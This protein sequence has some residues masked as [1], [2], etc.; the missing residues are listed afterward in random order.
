MVTQLKL[1]R[2]KSGIKQWRLAS[3]VG[4][5]QSE[6]SCYESGRRRCPADLRHRI[7]E[8]LGTKEE[9]LFPNER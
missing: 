8:K 9:N 3:L 2:T 6:L 1:E 5:S 7:A 4:I